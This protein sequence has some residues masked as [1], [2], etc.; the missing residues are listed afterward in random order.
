VILI[1]TCAYITGTVTTLQQVH[2]ETAA[3]QTDTIRFLNNTKDTSVPPLCKIADAKRVVAVPIPCSPPIV[4]VDSTVRT[5]MPMFGPVRLPYDDVHD[6]SMYSKEEID[7][8]SDCLEMYV[9][10]EYEY[11]AQ[12]KSNSRRNVAGAWMNCI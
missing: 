11:A 12:L 7:N 1:G 10:I 2:A 6:I 8:E 4:M 3:K 9:G 5:T